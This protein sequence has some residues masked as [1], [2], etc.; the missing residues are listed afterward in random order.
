LTT[1]VRA[2][3]CRALV[4][5]ALLLALPAGA[6]SIIDLSIELVPAIC[7]GSPEGQF[8]FC[9]AMGDLDGDGAPE[10]V[11]GAP[12]MPGPTGLYHTGGV[13]IFGSSLAQVLAGLEFAGKTNPSVEG[14]LPV[15]SDEM[16]LAFIGGSVD[17][18]RFGQALAIG[19]FDGDGTD[20]LAVG[21][22]ETDSGS[23]I[24]CGTVSVFFGAP[25]RPLRGMGDGAPDLVIEGE[26]AG[27]R[28][29]SALTAV[30]I[31][32]DGA[33]ELLVAAPGG[34]GAG[35][36]G[37]GLVSLFTGNALRGAVGSGT[38]PVVPLDQVMESEITGESPGDALGGIAAGD[39]DGDGKVD[40]V[41]G[42]YQAD[43]VDPPMTDAGR[44][45]VIPA[46]AVPL[47]GATSLPIPGAGSIEGTVERGFL[48][49]SIAVA[50]I[51]QDGSDDLLVSE[52]GSGAGRDV[53]EATGEAF[54]M[55]GDAELMEGAR[56]LTEVPATRL[57]ARARWDM[58]GL[59]VHLSDLNGDG[60]ADVIVASQFADGLSGD[61]ES[62]G[63][64]YVFRGSLKSVMAAKAGSAERADVTVV[65]GR[66]FD[67]IGGA[68]LVGDIIGAD[69]PELLIGAPDAAGWTVDGGERVG[70]LI[71]VP[72]QML[73]R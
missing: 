20:D 26:T 4:S 46:G 72:D 29:G 68:L 21:A 67:S 52:Y 10:L 56:S 70:M 11:V 32:E 30:D 18:G 9:A 61:R 66:P 41:L 47:N 59:P 73:A 22:P 53:V 71:I 57:T 51:D 31:N 64:V 8:G 19:D 65:G 6:E 1:P 48:G 7:G 40:L 62:C 37:P 5:F 14:A 27:G 3:V 49:R 34:G 45:Y 43:T 35:R 12:G 69:A 16:A 55:F 54:I 60:Y 38:R 13:Y 44:L 24:A 63:E 58:F 15:S 17:R 25:G 2:Q 39:I 36:V 33:D 42:A 50:D 28:L 23:L